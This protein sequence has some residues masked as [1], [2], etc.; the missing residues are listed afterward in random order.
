MAGRTAVARVLVHVA[1]LLPLALLVWNFTQNQLTVN[2]IEE[3]TRRTGKTALVL[4][5][6]SLACA[7]AF[8]FVRF[9]PL[10]LLARTLGLYA[11]A[12]ACVHLVIFVGIDYGFDL[13]QI[14][15]GVLEKRYALAGMCAYLLLM[16]LALTSTN[17]WRM[18]LGWTW[19]WL[20][21][22]AY[23][24]ALVAVVHYMWGVKID[25]PQPLQ[26]GAAVLLLILLRLPA[27]SMLREAG[28]QRFR[29]LR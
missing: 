15:E 6:L 4:L 9:R 3:A 16:A 11:F 26:Y 21:R 25:R 12:Y 17:G 24:A 20:H 1:L 18:R 19:H 7:P 14:Q 8:F 10:L 23:L 2:P 28:R 27:L 22:S 5:I 13:G 29:S